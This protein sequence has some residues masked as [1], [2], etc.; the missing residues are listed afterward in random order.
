[1]KNY[2]VA[3]S[4]ILFYISFGIFLTMTLLRNTFFYQYFMGITYKAGLAVCVLLLLVNELIFGR[5]TKR[6]YISIIVCTV[7]CGLFFLIP[8]TQYKV[9][10][11]TVLYII[12][13]R[14]I[15]FTNIAR[16]AA[17]L[18]AV[19]LVIVVLSSY[20]GIIENY[21]GTRT[22][23]TTRRYIGFLYSLYPATI[24]MNIT[25]LVMY[26]RKN[27]ILWREIL[28][29][30]FANVWIYIETGARLSFI[31]SV[32]ALALSA[33]LKWK[34]DFFV[35][36]K[37][38]TFILALAFI[39][40]AIISV[41]VTVY[42][43]GYIY[44]HWKINK[45]LSSRLMLQQEALFKYGVSIFGQDIGSNGNGLDP[46]GENP[47]LLTERYFYVDNEYIRWMTSYGIIFFVVVM[48]ILTW[49]C[50]KC[51]KYDKQGYLL[52]I[53]VLLAIHC[54][55]QDSF[56]YVYF[57]T[58]LLAIGSVLISNRSE[59]RLR[60]RSPGIGLSS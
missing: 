32:V 49:F 16:F 55:I 8:V 12:A 10:A 18:S 40:C 35:R 37:N 4:H 59:E 27:K 48:G 56:L 1:M 39:I 50:I 52:I 22:D 25:L 21:V 5:M 3:E 31:I 53:F 26:W 15:P 44:W 57:N 2:K 20:V 23:G 47:A 30:L 42:Y 38:L 28:I 33:L 29:L 7:L 9:M 51:R 45:I 17:I 60:A 24:I 11:A 19:F 14:K 58:F 34:P 6:G 54:T 43:N 36:K 46:F 41:L 13:A